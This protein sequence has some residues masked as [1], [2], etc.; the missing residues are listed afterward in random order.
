MLLDLGDPHLQSFGLR[1]EQF[2]R[3][4]FA[5]DWKNTIGEGGAPILSIYSGVPPIKLLYGGLIAGKVALIRLW[6][7]EADTV[8]Q[9]ALRLPMESRVRSMANPRK[10]CLP[11]PVGQSKASRTKVGEV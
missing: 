1:L 10:S 9:P 2:Q 3:L 6:P 4:P 7:V 5:H 11:S 8:G